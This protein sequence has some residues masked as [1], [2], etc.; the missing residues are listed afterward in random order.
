M[1]ILYMYDE[2]IK[3]IRD[4]PGSTECMLTAGTPTKVPESL[5]ATTEKDKNAIHI[6]ES[7]R[8]SSPTTILYIAVVPSVGNSIVSHEFSFHPTI[9]YKGEMT[10][11]YDPPKQLQGRVKSSLT[12]RKYTIPSSLVNS[13]SIIKYT[14]KTQTG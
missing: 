10:Q 6:D 3:T 4:V 2:T 12:Y 7:F 13:N 5:D 1:S 11:E 8:L 9:T 14:I